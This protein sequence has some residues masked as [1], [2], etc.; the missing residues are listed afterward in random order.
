MGAPRDSLARA[1]RVASHASCSAPPRPMIRPRNI[2]ITIAVLWGSR[3]QA[4]DA[5]PAAGTVEPSAG[6]SAPEPAAPAEAIEV[7]DE[8]PD[9]PFDRDT[10]L[11]LTGAQL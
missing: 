3:A 6:P 9:K 8:R 4:D 5:P 2:L 1:R 7:F 10:E 11:R